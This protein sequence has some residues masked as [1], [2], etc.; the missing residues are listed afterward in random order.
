[1]LTAVLNHLVINVT[2]APHEIK[3]ILHKIRG[4]VMLTDGTSFRTANS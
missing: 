4:K 3:L 2:R 1:M